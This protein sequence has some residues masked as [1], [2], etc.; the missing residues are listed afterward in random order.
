MSRAG[1]R[2][3]CSF[4]EP[5]MDRDP[6]RL[7]TALWAADA[8]PAR[9][10]AFEL[11]VMEALARRRLLREVLALAP[12]TAAGAALLWALGPVVGA[13]LAPVLAGA[14]ASSLGE[15]AAAAVMAAF[16]WAWASD[17]LAPTPGGGP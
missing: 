17:R 1:V 8:P 12:A 16:L 7:L 5:P 2:N 6:D 3:S 13:A 10:P 11:A 4:W 9:D 15:A 14:G